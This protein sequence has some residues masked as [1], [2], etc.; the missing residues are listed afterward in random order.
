MMLKPRHEPAVVLP[1][2]GSGVALANVGSLLLQMKSF[3]FAL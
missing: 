2:P 3:G 1:P